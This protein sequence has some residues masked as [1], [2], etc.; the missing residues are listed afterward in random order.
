VLIESVSD[1]DTDLLAAQDY[2]IAHYPGAAISE[3]YG[4]SEC[5]T[6]TDPTGAS[7]IILVAEEASYLGAT[8]ALA[9]KTHDIIAGANGLDIVQGYPATPG[10]DLSSGWGSP[11]EGLVRLLAGD[12]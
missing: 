3:S 5:A 6:L 1:N 10:W 2:A 12:D 4:S 8:G 11:S 7:Q 9:G